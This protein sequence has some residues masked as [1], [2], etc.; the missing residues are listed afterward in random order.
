ME[1]ARAQRA[2]VLPRNTE[3][4]TAEQKQEIA[5]IE[6]RRLALLTSAAQPAGSP[7]EALTIPEHPTE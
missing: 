3:Q 5:A 4:L 1:R 2:A 6:A 7:P